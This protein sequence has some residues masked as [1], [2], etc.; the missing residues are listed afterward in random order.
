LFLSKVSLSLATLSSRFTKVTMHSGLK[1]F[2][3]DYPI[4]EDKETKGK[5]HDTEHQN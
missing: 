4:D 3:L 2:S 5:I 1:S